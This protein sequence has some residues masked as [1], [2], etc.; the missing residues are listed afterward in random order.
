[1]VLL[2]QFSQARLEAG[3]GDE[4]HH[5]VIGF[6]FCVKVVHSD[7]VGVAEHGGDF[8]LSLEAGQKVILGG[9]EGM[10]NFDGYVAIQAWLVCLVDL[11][12]TTSTQVPDNAILA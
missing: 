9:Q 12:H 2:I 6:I 11:G 1:M 8:C 4:L 5:H 3:A 7:D 10:Q